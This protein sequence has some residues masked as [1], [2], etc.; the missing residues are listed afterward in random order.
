MTQ[1]GVCYTGIC[2]NVLVAADI[3]YSFENPGKHMIEKVRNL[4]TTASLPVKC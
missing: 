3:S 4:P 1:H 2:C